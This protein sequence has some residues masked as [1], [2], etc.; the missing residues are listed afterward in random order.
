[1]NLQQQEQFYNMVSRLKGNSRA[2]SVPKDDAIVTEIVNGLIVSKPAKKI[3]YLSET[4]KT[5]E[6]EAQV[7]NLTKDGPVLQQESKAASV[8]GV[9]NER[10]WS[11]KQIFDRPVLI[12]MQ[13]LPT[14]INKLVITKL[15]S[16]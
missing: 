7:W 16:A 6:Q 2:T 10:L 4:Q 9:N 11:V 14:P 1:M 13:F 15:V 5:S 8:P 3:E 12:G